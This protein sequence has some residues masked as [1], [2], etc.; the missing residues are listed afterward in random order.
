MIVTQ[1]RERNKSR[2]EVLVD[3]EIAFVLYKGD[4]RKYRIHDGE[5]LSEEVY[6][7]ITEE[8]LPKRAKLRSMNLLKDR[9]Y[10]QEELIRKLR[11]GG[12]P[13]SVIVIAL[14]YVKSY[15][16]IDDENYVRKYIETYYERKSK[17]QMEEKLRQKGITAATFRRIYDSLELT[18]L[19]Q[20]E[21][22][23]VY[24]LLEKKHYDPKRSTFE[25][26]RKIIGF[27]MRKGY[28]SAV[29]R[30]CMGSPEGF[31]DFGI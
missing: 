16:Y 24:K 20:S 12:Y 2:C 22:A 21:E 8:L 1:I 3:G 10:T 28:R 4:L 15:H 9:D 29:I 14:D 11:T 13:E 30:K 5:E 23:Q 19:E 31:E 18:D 26:K 7:E 17:L 6:R 27:L 25:E